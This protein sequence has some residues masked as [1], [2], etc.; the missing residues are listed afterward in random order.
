MHNG[1]LV[2]TLA[3]PIL[4][5]QRTKLRGARAPQDELPPTAPGP[6]KVERKVPAD[7]VV[8]VTRQRLR[9]GRTYAGK[10]VTIHVEDTH[11]RVT[12]D[13]AEL[14]VHPRREQRP[15]IRFKAKI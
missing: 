15:V 6:I 8:M 1:V 14:A 7:G 5:D 10:I 2:K 4:A 13:G 9:I 11:F 3:S 12:L